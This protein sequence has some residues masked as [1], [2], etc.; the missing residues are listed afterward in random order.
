MHCIQKVTDD[1]WWVGAN[2]RRLAMFEGVYSVPGGVSYNSYLL[3]DEKTVLLDTVDKAVRERFL[4]NVT[5]ALGGRPLDYLL[6]HHVE[7]D[8]SAVIQDIVGRYPDLRIVCSSKV[9]EFIRQFYDFEDEN[10]F[11]VVGENDALETGKHCVS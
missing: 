7:P 4:E 3:T 1:L 5:E 9:L 10:R 11:L 2:D 8:H 6:V